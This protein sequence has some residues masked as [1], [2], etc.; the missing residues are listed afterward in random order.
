LEIGTFLP[1]S[2][3]F[4]SETKYNSGNPS[5]LYTTKSTQHNPFNNNKNTSKLDEKKI[6]N[7]LYISIMQNFGNWDSF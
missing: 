2:V 4:I 7:T 6:L 1:L 3:K 5:I